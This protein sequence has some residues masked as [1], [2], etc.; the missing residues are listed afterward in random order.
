M[1]DNV[2]ITAGSGTTIAAD[3]VGGVLFQRVKSVLG[4][5]GVA[6]DPSAGAGA[7][8]TGVQ[9]VTLASD[10]PAVAKVTNNSFSNTLAFTPAATSHT[11]GDVNGAA[12]AFTSMGTASSRVMITSASML[13]NTATVKASAF[14]LYLYNVTPPSATADD[15]AWDLP[16]GDQASFLGYVDLGTP[17]DLGS[18]QW[19][20]V[21]GI[22]K[23]ILLAATPS[24]F[25]YLVNLTTVTEEAV[26]HT[27]TLHT[28]GV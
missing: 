23:Q 5:D 21:H 1:A 24:I 6:V 15:A 20:E 10:D 14:R 13:I 11:A 17:I 8:G 18:S 2:S 4:A 25:A 27:V 22:N 3:D 19:V 9:R 26:A 12:G 16:S 7:V 28:V